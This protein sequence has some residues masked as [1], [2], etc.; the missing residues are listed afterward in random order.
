MIQFNG[1]NGKRHS[2]RLGRVNRKQAE[3]AGRL[4]EELVAWRTGGSGL[5]NSTAEW[6]NSLP[7]VIHKRLARAGLVEPR[8]YSEYPTI[9]AWVRKYIA[10]RTDVKKRTKINLEQAEKDLNKFFGESR[11]LDEVTPGDAE[12][13]RTF[14]KTTR[15]LGEG[16]VR[17]HVKRARQF[18][19]AAIKKKI[20]TEN[21]FAGIK[22]GNYSDTTRFHYISREEAQVVIDGCPDPEWRLIFA[23]CRFGGLRCP[24]EVLALKWGDVDWARMRLAVHASK[25]EHHDG[26][27]RHI[28]IFP[29]LYPNLRECFEQAELGQEYVVAHYRG[30]SENLRTRLTSIIKKAGLEPWPKLFQNCRSTRETE[31][32]EQFPLHVV[33]QWIGNSEA[34]AAKHYLQVTEDQFRAAVGG[35]GSNQ[36]AGALQKLTQQEAAGERTESPSEKPAELEGD[37]KSL[38]GESLQK[39]AA[40]CENTEPQSISVMVPLRGL[41]PLS[42]G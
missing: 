2:L 7:A 28:P 25:T 40:P 32:A 26:G 19:A 5:S 37:D 31:L 23:L 42:S 20:I 1:T 35:G 10:G 12:E 39:D 24:S 15:Q 38:S 30:G 16:T 21:P 4:V 13:F 17:R 8:A 3:T 18:F 33:C 34:V 22:C 9:T 29:E 6:V 27:T 11:R 41:E 14:L 36:T